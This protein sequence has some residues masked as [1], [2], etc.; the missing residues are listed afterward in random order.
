M[1]CSIYNHDLICNLI[2][3]LERVFGTLEISLYM[4]KFMDLVKDVD[5]FS[6]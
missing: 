3:E 4:N 1:P 5:D 6:M 2:Y